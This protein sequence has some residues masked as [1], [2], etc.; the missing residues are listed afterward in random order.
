M[1]GIA[2]SNNGLCQLRQLFQTVLDSEPE[3]EEGTQSYEVFPALSKTASP[4][5][6]AAATEAMEVDEVQ[7]WSE[8][9]VCFCLALDT[10]EKASDESKY[11]SV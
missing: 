1:L 5:V 7:G 2:W 10:Q 11:A 9:A 3:E 6:A 4:A 8:S